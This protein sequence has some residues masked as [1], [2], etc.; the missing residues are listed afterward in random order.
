MQFVYMGFRH[1]TSGVRL[2]SFEGVAA[3]G[4]RKAFQVTADMN[5]LAKH[6]VR[7][8]EAPMMCLRLLESAAAGQEQPDSLVLTET[9]IIAHV[10]AQ[11][12]ERER[13]AAK[14]TRR[15]FKP[16]GQTALATGWKS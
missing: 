6:H 4:V 9:A 2:Y 12:A 1:E 5:L 15:P 3:E 11:T 10:L 16:A 8:Q 14:K 7:I 13:A